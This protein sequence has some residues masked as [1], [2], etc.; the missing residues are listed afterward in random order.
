MEV[1]YVIPTLVSQSLAQL[2]RFEDVSSMTRTCRFLHVECAPLLLTPRHLRAFAGEGIESFCLFMLADKHRRFALLSRCHSLSILTPDAL[3]EPV[4][5]ILIDTLTQVTSLRLIRFLRF[6]T[7]IA[8]SPRVLPAL[9]A[10]TWFYHIE[11]DSFIFT[12]LGKR[13]YAK[14]LKTLKA[15][16][17]NAVK[18]LLPF[19][20]GGHGHVS[21]TRELDPL[22]LL[23]S[24]T[25]T[26]EVLILVATGAVT[27]APSSSAYVYPR[28]TYLT[29][30]K[31][32]MAFVY[33]YINAFP[34]L[35]F[36]R[37][38]Y[39]DYLWGHDSIPTH[40]L[41]AHSL[42]NKSCEDLRKHNRED[43]I[44]HG[45]WTALEYFMGMTL[46]AYM[47]GL[48]CRIS[49]LHLIAWGGTP[50]SEVEAICAIFA[51]ARPSVF[52]LA[53]R[54]AHIDHLGAL[55]YERVAL[56]SSISSLELRLDVAAV[57]F[58]FKAYLVRIAVSIY[59]TPRCLPTSSDCM[60]CRPG[61]CRDRASTSPYSLSTSG[62]QVLSAHR[63]EEVG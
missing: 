39:S 47:A 45:S 54:P 44:V 8:S 18:L 53:L 20:R 41:F 60:F 38:D 36:L 17:L 7:L 30:P 1:N 11:I 3:S 24:F 49:K 9:A 12:M 31:H 14:F 10:L 22:W 51:D 29:I 42:R 34:S 63:N 43:Q 26:L 19:S 5:D 56:F 13:S 4:V 57:P 16:G 58:D 46:D 15:P 21:Y 28:L 25:S 55:F 48:T 37:F 59:C 50:D 2:H 61:H 23:S 27:V 40:S 32:S 6:E 52:R 62:D 33:P 35:R